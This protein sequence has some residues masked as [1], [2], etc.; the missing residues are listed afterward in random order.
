MEQ[1]ESITSKL[2]NVKRLE[3]YRFIFQLIGLSI[4]V[5]FG[6][7][8]TIF[9]ILLTVPLAL[10]VGPAYCGWMCPRGMFQN[11]AGILGRKF[12]GKRYN[13]LIS[14]KVHDKLR[15]IRYILL[16]FVLATVIIYEFEILGASVEAA[17]VDGLLAIMVFSILLSFFVDRAACRY[18][19]KDGA[20]ASLVNLV[21][22]RK[23]KREESLCNSCGIC[24][25]VCPMWI[26]V[27]TADMVRITPA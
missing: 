23:I 11:L 7:E 13:R 17:I 3:V 5:Y 9:V 19:C 15:Y 21:K 27:S 2:K 25:R 26:E 1:S 8:S 20:A 18:F 4:F 14:R 12:L 6:R 24:D 16:L 22:I 10:L